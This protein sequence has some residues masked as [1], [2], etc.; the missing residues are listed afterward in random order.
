MTKLQGILGGSA[1]L[2]VLA[3]AGCSKNKAVVFAEEYAD[4]TCACK[5]ADCVKRVS[6]EM[7]KKAGEMKDARGS[8][9]DAKL[10]ES[11]MKRGVDCAAKLAATGAGTDDKKEEK[12]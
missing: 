5:D 3:L 10:V 4:K 7:G 1:V 8:A 12:K 11:A 6:E 2:A 9:D